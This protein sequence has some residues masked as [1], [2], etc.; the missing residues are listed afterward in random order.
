M[1]AAAILAG[2]GRERD[3]GTFQGLPD[4]AGG[5]RL[6]T[7]TR[8]LPAALPIRHGI[9]M[10]SGC[11]GKIGMRP[12]ASQKSSQPAWIDPTQQGLLL[13]PVDCR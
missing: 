10:Q 11:F 6:E 3:A 7:A 8:D 5:V 12:A 2:L 13:S 1:C 4:V 9:S